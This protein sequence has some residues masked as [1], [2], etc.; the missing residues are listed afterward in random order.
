MYWRAGYIIGYI[1]ACIEGIDVT[2]GAEIPLQHVL[3]LV[4]RSKLF[5]MLRQ[6]SKGNQKVEA[7]REEAV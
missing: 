7:I 4:Q 6:G 3:L 5:V 1:V 2:Y